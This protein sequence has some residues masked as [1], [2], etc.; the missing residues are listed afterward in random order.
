MSSEYNLDLQ[1]P[2]KRKDWKLLF[3][4]LRMEKEELRFIFENND[5]LI[6]TV[7]TNE[8]EKFVKQYNHNITWQQKSLRVID[9]LFKN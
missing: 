1:I 9:Y 8:S 2:Q 4:F 3:F 7:S 5:N 6:M